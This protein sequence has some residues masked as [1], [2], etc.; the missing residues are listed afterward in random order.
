MRK[1]SEVED[2]KAL[3]S[4]AVG[5]S[6][7]KWLREKKRVRKAADKANAALD[8]LE[9]ETKELW[10]DDLKA[11]YRELALSANDRART[12]IE[13]VETKITPLA[14]TVKK[15]DDAAY[16]AHM[17]AEDTFDE[18]ERQL[19]TRL[20]REGSRRAITSWELHEAAIRKA[21]QAASRGTV[22]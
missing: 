8:A 12:Q 1:L 3:M 21:E 16:R 5:W 2:A 13:S 15:A 10:D 17:D 18:A 7:V 11:A 22:K 14:K 19:S 4:E 9:K 20:A 6:V